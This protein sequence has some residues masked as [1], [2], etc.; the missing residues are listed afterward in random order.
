MVRSDCL[1]CGCLQVL[2]IPMMSGYTPPILR[3]R[4]R[5]CSDRW[6]LPLWVLV[7]F[8][9][10]LSLHVRHHS[11]AGSL[12]TL[13]HQYSTASPCINITTTTIISGFQHDCMMSLL[14]TLSGSLAL[15]NRSSG[16]SIGAERFC[17]AVFTLLPL[18]VSFGVPMNHPCEASLI[19]SLS[20]FCLQTQS[21][22]S[23]A[24][25]TLCPS[26][27]GF[28][29]LS[30]LFYCSHTPLFT[31]EMYASHYASGIPTAIPS[32]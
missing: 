31:C 28:V 19:H 20:E 14:F 5:R 16:A 8:F 15:F 3:E 4:G 27:P 2:H 1:G 17:Y 21:C 29:E 10:L 23:I 11:F 7:V 26:F 25:R 9:P 32:G 6:M 24:C 18:V 30:T 12:I 22:H 13:F